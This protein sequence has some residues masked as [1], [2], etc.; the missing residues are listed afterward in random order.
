MKG[1]RT[2]DFFNT[3]SPELTANTFKNRCQEAQL[4]NQTERKTRIIIVAIIWLVIVAYLICPLSKARIVSVSGNLTMLNTNDLYE[5]GGFSSSN[6]IWSLNKDTIKAN[7]RNYDYINDADISITPFGVKITID[8]I[9]VVGKSSATC[10]NYGD[11]CIYYLSNGNEVSGYND[12]RA[13]NLK[14]IANFGAIPYIDSV[15]K[16]SEAQKSVLFLELGKV[17][18]DI[19]NS[20]STIALNKDVT[21]NTVVNVTFNGAS[22]AL[23]ADLELQ[24]DAAGISSKLTEEN[25]SY[26]RDVIAKSAVSKEKGYCYI[27]RSN[28]YVLP[29]ES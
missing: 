20:I 21:N 24:V 22:I 6:F 25:L 1:E 16:M 18:K 2:V 15:D 11:N 4:K 26:I 3:K 12:Y 29:C 28:D 9:S 27:Y 13:N 19:R 5:I 8:E 17:S 10:T 7:Y 23:N 14:H